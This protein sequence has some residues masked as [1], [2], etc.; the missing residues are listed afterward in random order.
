MT[1]RK[2]SY[3]VSYRSRQRSHFVDSHVQEL[4]RLL[5][6][7]A[8]GHELKRGQACLWAAFETTRT[9][10]LDTHMVSTSHRPRGQYL[11]TGGNEHNGWLLRRVRY[12]GCVCWF[13]HRGHS[14]TVVLSGK[15]LRVARRQG[16]REKHDH[17]HGIGVTER[18]QPCNRDD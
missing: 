7:G 3:L 1:P 5:V 12:N 9:T 10:S 17:T 8:E 6:S 11:A 2:V 15:A 16:D 18:Q 13:V 4:R 14:R